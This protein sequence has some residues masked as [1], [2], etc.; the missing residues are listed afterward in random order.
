MPIKKNR[1]HRHE[2]GDHFDLSI[3]ILNQNWVPDNK[4][5]AWINCIGNIF[6]ATLPSLDDF[7]SLNDTLNASANIL[8]TQI[9]QGL[10]RK[11]LPQKLTDPKEGILCA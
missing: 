10:K 11:E 6:T 2:L 7:Q 5:V 8:V 4:T 1:I 9:K 3:L